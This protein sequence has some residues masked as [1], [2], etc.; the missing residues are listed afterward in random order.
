MKLL[1]L[2]LILRFILL[3]SIITFPAYIMADDNLSSTLVN[4]SKQNGSDGFYLVQAKIIDENE[5]VTVEGNKKVN[6]GENAQLKIKKG[7]N[8]GVVLYKIFSV[9]D[10]KEMGYL[11][12]SFH[13]GNF[14][15]DVTS[16]CKGSECKFY[17][18]NPEQNRSK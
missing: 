6:P 1:K 3:T 17:D 7:C 2:L 16:I 18:L 8:W 9:K 4:Q 11:G 13:D 15:I 5:C 12:H 10:N 14:S